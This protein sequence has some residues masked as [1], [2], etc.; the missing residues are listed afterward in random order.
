[1]ECIPERSVGPTVAYCKNNATRVLDH[2]DAE[3]EVEEPEGVRSRAVGNKDTEDLDD[4]GGFEEREDGIA[5]NRGYG[6]LLR[7]DRTWL[8]AERSS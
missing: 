5:E 2:I 6:A 3:E 8:V 7:F 1:M 4:D